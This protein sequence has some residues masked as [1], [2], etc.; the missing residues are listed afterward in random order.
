MNPLVSTDWVQITETEAR[1]L[2]CVKALRALLEAIDDSPHLV[3]GEDV[4]QACME[5]WEALDA[6]DEAHRD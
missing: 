4:D 5:G 3:I 6:Y 2:A 1:A